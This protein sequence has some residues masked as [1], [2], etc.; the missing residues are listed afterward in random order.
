MKRN[1]HLI[2][3]KAVILM[4]ACIAFCAV[5]ACSSSSASGESA[6]SNNPVV[7]AAQKTSGVSWV[8]SRDSAASLSGWFHRICSALRNDQSAQLVTLILE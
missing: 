2:G 4:L 5:S 3:S 7:A 1:R 6:G 8:D